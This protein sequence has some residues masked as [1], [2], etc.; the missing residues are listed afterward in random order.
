MRVLVVGSGLLGLTTAYFLRREGAD[1][2]VVDR[3]DGPGRDTS[4]A[5]GGLIHAGQA[6]PWNDPD[7]MRQVLRTFGREHAALLVRMHALPRLWRWGISFLLQSRRVRFTANLAR[8]ARL[9]QYAIGVLKELREETTFDY[10]YSAGGIITVYRTAE[11]LDS[12]QAYSDHFSRYGIEHRLLE[13]NEIAKLEPALVPVL[14]RFVGGLY[15]PG[16]ESGD[17]F[18]FCCDL[19][20]ACERLGVE[21]RYRTRIKKLVTGK[22]L[23][24]S[25]DTD[26]HRLRA[27]CFVLAAG[28]FTPL[29]AKTAGLRVP[30]EP[31][32]GYSLTIPFGGWPQPPAVPVIDAHLHAALCP[33]GD[34]L[35][36]A[37]TA[38]FAGYSR[39][40]TKSR[41][42]NL[43]E[44]TRSVYPEFEPHIRHEST[45]RWT[46][47]RPMTPDGVGVMG[48]TP[49][50]NLYLNT[51]HGHLGW[52]MAA[53]AGKAVAQ[54][55]VGAAAE[56]DLSE[57][58]LDRFSGFF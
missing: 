8:N 20:R 7:V 58:G 41:I 25:A 18:K 2:C 54:Q 39:T 1:V 6:S 42:D 9:A 53:G 38:E 55:I 27:D 3:D 12:A 24:V 14:D 28:S 5:N 17:A 19:H 51:G 33:L 50:S 31:V 56:F 37:G 49:L 36:V 57:Y 44:L 32:K 15:F 4:F 11:E 46:G 13:Q 26:D 30:V 45:D 52:T 10:D 40:L 16:D 29:L 48:A 22:G 43:F 47:L 21:F 35:R 23:V 34:R